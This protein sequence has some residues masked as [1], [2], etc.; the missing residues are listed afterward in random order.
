MSLSVQYSVRVQT[1]EQVYTVKLLVWCTSVSVQ[2]KVQVYTVKLLVW[3]TSV[4]VQTKVQVYTV[5][6]SVVYSVHTKCS[7]CIQ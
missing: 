3:C 1:K 2:T 5:I 4:S 7:L 6:V